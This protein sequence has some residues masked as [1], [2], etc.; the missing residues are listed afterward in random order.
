MSGNQQ[1][2]NDY[3]LMRTGKARDEGSALART[4]VMGAQYTDPE[5][6]FN[7]G[8]IPSMFHEAFMEGYNAVAPDGGYCVLRGKIIGFS[9]MRGKMSDYAWMKR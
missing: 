2:W 5:D 7:Y 9:V 4:Q 3:D 1:A 6:Y 8:V